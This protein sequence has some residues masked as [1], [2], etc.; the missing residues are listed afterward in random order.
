MLFVKQIISLFVMCLCIFTCNAR[1]VNNT[2]VRNVDL[3]NMLGQWYEIA[4]L[5]NSVERGLGYTRVDYSVN[6]D[7]TIH[8]KYSGTR[9]GRRHV[10]TGKA[11]VTDTPGLLRVSFCRPFYSDLRIL[12][13]SDDYMYA[14]LGS[15]GDDCLWILSRT[16][17]VPEAVADAIVEEAHARGYD[18]DELLWVTQ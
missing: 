2:P 16:P 4:R 15:R 18:T 8:I 12:M 5:D 17:K 3:C 6:E 1:A 14:L 10:K 7:G 13:V 11:K 9:G